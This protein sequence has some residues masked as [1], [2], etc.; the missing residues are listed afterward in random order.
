MHLLLIP[1]CFLLICML[2]LAP[3]QGGQEMGYSR[4]AEHG[5]EQLREIRDRG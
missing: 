4:D 3:L 2:L 1:I 5:G